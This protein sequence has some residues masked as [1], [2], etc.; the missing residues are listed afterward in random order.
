MIKVKPIDEE[1][2]NG[3]AI[4][5]SGLPLRTVNACTATGITTIGIL[6]K[7]KNSDLYMI[8]GMGTQSIQAIEK[9]FSICDEIQAGNKTFKDLRSIFDFFLSPVQ[10]EVLA[11]RYKLQAD[12][13][14]RANV[15]GI[16]IL[17]TTE[18][19]S[20]FAESGVA[21]YPGPLVRG[22]NVHSAKTDKF[23]SG[24]IP[25]VSLSL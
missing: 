19:R 24:L 3:W 25:R 8:K 5:D 12:E 6:R 15:S 22:M 1:T 20:F 23:V 7:K 2:I 18:A 9:F 10:Y 11:L 13:A 4:L 21:I 14:L 16:V 17:A